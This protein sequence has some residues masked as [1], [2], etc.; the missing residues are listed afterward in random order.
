MSTDTLASAWWRR[1]ES[2]PRP[3]QCECGALLTELRPQY[4]YYTKNPNVPQRTLSDTRDSK[5]YVIAK[6]A[7]GK[8]WML[9]N[10]RI[11]TS[12]ITLTPADSDVSANFAI[13]ASAIQSSGN[14]SWTT[15]NAVRIY[16]NNDTWIAPTSSGNNATINTT[17]TPPSQSQYIGNYYNWYTATAGTGTAAMASGNTTSSICPKGW[18]L[19]TVKASTTSSTGDFQKLYNTYTDRST[20]LTAMAIVFSGFRSG[21]TDRYV[22]SE[23]LLSSS[24]AKDNLIMYH[25]T[26]KNSSNYTSN[27][28]KIY[29]FPI[30]CVAR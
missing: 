6:L 17:G 26:I 2:N 29:G 16:N 10:L 5:T 3:P 30:R 21:T 9:Q 1:W 8:C 4:H 27:S 24:T 11:G 25:A 13:P 12:A 20:F 23:A 18:R 22:G 19:P 15:A 14:T 28:N 7:D